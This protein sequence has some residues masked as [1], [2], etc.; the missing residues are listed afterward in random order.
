MTLEA[1][2]LEHDASVA[3]TMLLA[4]FPID[5]AIYPT[6]YHEY[7]FALDI[8]GQLPKGV[9]VDLGAGFDPKIH[10]LA[11]ALEKS[12]WYVLALDHDH[13]SLAMPKT[14]KTVRMLADIRLPWQQFDIDADLVTC[15]STLEHFDSMTEQLHVVEAAWRILRPGG[16]FVATADF[17]SPD[18]LNKLLQLGGFTVGRVAEQ[19]A[20]AHLVPRVSAA[21]GRREG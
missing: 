13:K 8:A 14:E 2:W 1:R 17:M 10:I 15:I 7:K 3:G 18:R 20:P 4:D 19:S 12:G 5:T 6:R 16:V 11:W 21:A 9:A